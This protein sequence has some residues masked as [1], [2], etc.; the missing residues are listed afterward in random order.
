[1]PISASVFD[2]VLTEMLKLCRPSVVLDI[3]PGKGK[4]GKI[5]RSIESELD[6]AIHKMAVEIDREKVIERFALHEIYDEILN[7]D[8]AVLVKRYPLLTGDIVIVGD[9]IEHLTKSEGIDMIE[10]LQY[11]FKHIFMIIP[12]DWV[13]HSYQDYEN[14]SH[15]SIWRT[16]DITYFEGGYGVERLIETDNRFLLC[17]VNGIMLPVA[18]HFVVRDRIA[19]DESLYFDAEIEFGYLNR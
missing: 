13:S 1:M 6:C 7:E 10:Y 2:D 18:D 3:G 12:V 17:S 8:A 4:Y 11:R 5:L 9:V 14:E 15:I 16:K 19:T